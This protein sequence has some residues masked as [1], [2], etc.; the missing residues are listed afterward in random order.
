MIRLDR[1]RDD[2]LAIDEDAFVFHLLGLEI[3]PVKETI[4]FLNL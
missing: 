4:K 3:H 2:V 1:I